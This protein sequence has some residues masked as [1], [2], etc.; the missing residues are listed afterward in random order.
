MAY[1]SYFGN[2][3]SPVPVPIPTSQPELLSAPFAPQGNNYS[4]MPEGYSN[5]M[6]TP[7]MQ[8]YTGLGFPMGDTGYTSPTLSPNMQNMMGIESMGGP[9]TSAQSGSIWDTFLSN[10]NSQGWGGLALG[11]TSGLVNSFLGWQQLRQAK[12]ALAT[13]KDQFER[14]YAANRQ[15]TNSR[16]EDR[17][18]ARVASNPGYE[19]VGSY[20][21]RNRVA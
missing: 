14:N 17:Q 9:M 2:W 16:L 3:G 19:S 7:S 15:L 21:D 4:L 11:A 12:D 5:G 18:R 20:M 8:Q 6:L 13:S 1:D 10:R